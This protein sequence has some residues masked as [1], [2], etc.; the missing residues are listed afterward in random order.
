HR[1]SAGSPFLKL[2]DEPTIDE[3]TQ[4]NRGLVAWRSC[5]PLRADGLNRRRQVQPGIP[6]EGAPPLDNVNLSVSLTLPAETHRD[7]ERPHGQC[8]RADRPVELDIPVHA[9][10]PALC[11]ARQPDTHHGPAAESQRPT[12]WPTA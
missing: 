2:L 10:P 8:S 6:R 3:G 12:S 4:E 5:Q 11:L 7:L 1:T 9:Q